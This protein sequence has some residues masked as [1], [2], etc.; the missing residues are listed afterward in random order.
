[1]GRRQLG[2]VALLCEKDG[3]G[4]EQVKRR[5]HLGLLWREDPLIK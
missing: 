5:R 1:M 3:R 4:P 2:A